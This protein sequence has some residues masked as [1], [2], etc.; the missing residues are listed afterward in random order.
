MVC[1]S[2]GDHR[3]YGR[4]HPSIAYKHASEVIHYNHSGR[5]LPHPHDPDDPD[6]WRN[7]AP[8]IGA[9]FGPLGMAVGTIVATTGPGVQCK[10]GGCRTFSSSD[11]CYQSWEGCGCPLA[12]GAMPPQRGGCYKQDNKEITC[13]GCH[14]RTD[15][16]GCL[17]FCPRCQRLQ[18]DA[19]FSNHGCANASVEHV[20]RRRV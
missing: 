7:A 4:C 15:T 14:R 8:F 5:L 18:A 11:V 3:T 20:L 9:L 1:H 16:S 13:G 19:D 12:S 2:V 6:P 17:A 10:R